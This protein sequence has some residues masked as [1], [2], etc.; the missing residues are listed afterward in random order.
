MNK[1]VFIDFDGT[2]ADHGWVPPGH[3]EAVRAARAAGHRVFLCT[4]RPKVMVPRRFRESVFDGLVCAGGGYVEIGRQVLADLRF[5]PEL[6]RRT[7]AVLTAAK[8][9][10]LLEAPAA[11]FATVEAAER[12]RAIFTGPKWPTDAETGPGE[13]LEGLLTPDDLGNCS[14][15]KVS[16]LD[17]P[18][19]VPELAGA[20]G[21]EIGALP[22]SIT[23]LS[24]HAGELYQLGVDKATGI[25]VVATHLD[26]QR[27]DII[28]IGD[29]HNDLE[30]LTYAGTGVAVKGSPAE[31]RELA[32]LII[33][34]P[35][36]LGLVQGFT[37]LGLT[38][39]P[40]ET[41]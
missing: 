29:G 1:T 25:R 32:Q 10:F 8:A 21:P 37:E 9:A 7:A 23:G 39:A 17:S 30:M 11:L 3:L 20:I 13:L 15:G 22:N 31:V 40:Q 5:P 35:G 34:G 27:S 18:L 24:R 33:P 4:G 16:V 2:F 19:P 38:G 26:L 12:I 14:F 36:D 6:A 28:A 41:R